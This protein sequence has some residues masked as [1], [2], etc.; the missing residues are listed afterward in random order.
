[1]KKLF[2]LLFIPDL[3]RKIFFTL[4]MLAIYKLGI[5]ITVPGINR[6]VIK[7]YL[8]SL[9]QGNLDFFQM[10]NFFSG[11]GLEHGSIFALGVMPYISA[12]III[13]LVFAIF[14]FLKNSGESNIK[15]NKLKGRYIKYMTLFI[16]FIQSFAVA[17]Y[18]KCKHINGISII[19]EYWFYMFYGIGFLIITVL[20]LVA[21]ASFVMWI[22]E[23]ITNDGIC[24]GVSLIIFS[25]I[26][27]RIPYILNFIFHGLVD[28]VFT[29][30]EVFYLTLVV[31]FALFLIILIEEAQRR[32]PLR[33][34]R[35]VKKDKKGYKINH[36]PFK[37]NIAGVMPPIFASTILMCPSF[38]SSF[39]N[40]DISRK[41]NVIFSPNGFYYQILFALLVVFF[42]YFY[43]FMQF[44][45]RDI[46]YNI[47]KSGAFI[48]GVRPGRATFR[49]L[50]NMII[51]ITSISS[52]YLV[53][54]C[55]LPFFAQL[56]FINKIPFIF[57]GTSLLISVN[58]SI[59]IIK[60][61]DDCYKIN[62]MSIFLW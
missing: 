17:N 37:I 47:V 35:S 30:K 12:S 18:L 3:L 6:N 60:C 44:D 10:L 11:G 41:I 27:S 14:P 39:L 1:M 53:F 2:Y 49:Y 43:I 15:N 62:K 22:S 32:I 29:I 61:I 55:L 23:Q 21:G 38:L 13:S 50:N 24:N 19:Q 20:T 42:S 8:N 58:V 25:S 31:I 51:K 33:H 5:F 54:V 34:A 46:S 59:E 57:G 7:I 56:I 9:D 52:I 16:S 36:L 4:G 40:L 28:S 48:L 45:I 26:I